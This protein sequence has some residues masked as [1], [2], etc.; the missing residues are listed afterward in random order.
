MRYIIVIVF[1]YATSVCMAQERYYNEEF[2]F[3]FDIPSKWYITFEDEL[4]DDAKKTLAELYWSENLLVLSPY[5]IDA[6]EIPCILTQGRKSEES[7]NSKNISY[8]KRTSERKL[9]S[10]T[11]KM[12]DE[13]LGER[14]EQYHRTDY[15]YDYDTSRNLAIVKIIYENNLNKDVHLVTAIATCIGGIGS[16]AAIDFRGYWKGQYPEEFWNIFK[17]V[18]DSFEFDQDA[19]APKR[20]SEEI[21]H[22]T[23]KTVFR[24]IYKVCGS[25]FGLLIAIWILKKIFGW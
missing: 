21:S 24:L 19:V 11:E 5:G 14:I 7:F 22:E 20:T 10:S 23:A 12:V 4:S 2:G 1:L 8:F 6:L 17:G 13:L 15:F 3:A 18:V 25:F 16:E 9:T